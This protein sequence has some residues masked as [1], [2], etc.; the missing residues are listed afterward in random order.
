VAGK[1][2]SSFETQAISTIKK[3][4]ANGDRGRSVRAVFRIEVPLPIQAK[5][6]RIVM[7]DARS[8]R[9]GSEDAGP[10]MLPK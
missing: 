7:R 3:E 4:Q 8:G 6:M 5:R 9:T 1:T 2:L 10:E